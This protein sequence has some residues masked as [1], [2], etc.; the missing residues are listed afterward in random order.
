[1]MIRATIEMSPMSNR[2]LLLLLLQ[3]ANGRRAVNTILIYSDDDTCAVIMTC[4]SK[5]GLGHAL[6]L[7]MALC[8]VAVL[9][10]LGCSVAFKDSSNGGLEFGPW[11]N[12]SKSEGSRIRF[13][14]T[15]VAEE[16][17]MRYVI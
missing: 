8:F 3:L 6:A 1:M 14:K 9:V 12:K 15:E 10:L 4:T 16:V 11:R 17:G 7:V 2:S 5:F 13:G